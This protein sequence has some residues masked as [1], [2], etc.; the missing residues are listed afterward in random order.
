MPEFKMIIMSRRVDY[1][2]VLLS[3]L[4]ARGTGASARELAD[5]YRLSRPFVANILKHLCHEGL[6]ESQRGVRGG[7]RIAVEPQSITLKQ[8]ISALDGPLQLVCCTDSHEWF[9]CCVFDVCPVRQTLRGVHQ[10]LLAT[11]SEIT[12]AD[13][14]AP[15]SELVALSTERMDGYSTHLSRQ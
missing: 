14:A 11:L 5:R 9:D 7:Y 4:A 12:L 1:G 6:I 10:R 2:I 15:Q 13:L 3:D 8:I